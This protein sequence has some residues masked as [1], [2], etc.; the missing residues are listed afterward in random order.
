MEKKFATMAKRKLMKKEKET[1]KEKEI[2]SVKEIINHYQILGKG[3]KIPKGMSYEA[4]TALWKRELMVH[5][6][7]IFQKV[8]Q[9]LKQ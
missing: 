8:S 9:Y 5:R 6:D 7:K 2:E 1:K 4:T 3:G